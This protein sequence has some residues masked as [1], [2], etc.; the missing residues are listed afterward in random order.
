M[1]SFRRHDPIY[2]AQRLSTRRSVCL[3]CTSRKQKPTT[4]AKREHVGCWKETA[5]SHI[6]GHIQTSFWLP[7]KTIK[8]MR[9]SRCF[10]GVL[11]LK[12]CEKLTLDHDCQSNAFK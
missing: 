9:A 11:P 2:E 1:A 3:N 7:E 5:I 8:A 10:I 6:Q 4:L 12:F